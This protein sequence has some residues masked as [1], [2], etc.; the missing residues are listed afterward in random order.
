MRRT[1]LLLLSFVLLLCACSEKPDEADYGQLAGLHADYAAQTRAEVGFMMEASFRD[2]DTGQA[3]VLYYISGEARYDGTAQIAWQKF[4][5]TLLAA[6]SNAEEYYADGIKK[7]V[8]NGTV[9][10]LATAPEELFGA[11]PYHTVPLPAFS[12][13]KSLTVEESDGG[14]LYTLTASSGQK[15]LVEEIWRLDLYALAGIR[16]PDREKETY[17]DAVYTFSVADGRIRSLFVKLTVSLYETAGYTPGY[18]P[19]EEDYRLDLTLNAQ[20][21]LRA[22][23]EAVEI[24]VWEEQ[25]ELS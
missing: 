17:G 4:T 5:A 8:E 6:T 9:Y 12:G 11:F 10:D 2:P 16:L 22:E 3:G 24:P 19:K 20:I 13:V 23:G 1:G 14:M 15:Q 18:T 21:S 25:G 7:H